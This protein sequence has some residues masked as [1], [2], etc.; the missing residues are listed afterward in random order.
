MGGD[1]SPADPN[2]SQRLHK[3]LADWGIASRRQ[4][5][6]LIREGRV[7]LNGLVVTQLGTKANPKRDRIELDS[8]RLSPPDS[9]A[10]DTTPRRRYVLLHKP[11]GVLSTC[12]DPQ[13]RR[14]VLD[15]LPQAWRRS[16]RFYP[17]G[18]LDAASTGA[19]LLTNDGDLTFRL[20]HP[21]HHWPKTYRVEVEG[22]PPETI[23]QQWREGVELDG[24]RTLPAQVERRT[25]VPERPDRTILTVVLVEGRNRQIRRV[26]AL[27]GY[28][29]RSLHREAIG[30]IQ[31]GTLASGR[32]RNLRKNEI[33]CL[34]NEGSG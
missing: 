19:I 28:P 33:D 23:L 7:R 30:W 21:R 22:H 24:C 26:A 10:S 17:V 29:V 16:T 8:R 27:L 2:E 12:N 25:V 34:K 4:S 31:L 6:Q 11:A 32:Y 9:S 20:T 15:L 18:R 3:I 14:T 1:G 5:E 13:G